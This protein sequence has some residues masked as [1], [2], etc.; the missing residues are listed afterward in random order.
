MD[1]DTAHQLLQDFELILGFAQQG[2]ATIS[3]FTESP[4]FAPE[5]P[6]TL[7]AKDLTNSPPTPLLPPPED[8]GEQFPKDHGE[9]FPDHWTPPSPPDKK[10]A[11]RARDT[12]SSRSMA[13]RPTHRQ[14]APFP[15]DRD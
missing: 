12:N 9:Q 11:R 3:V 2:I 6:S 14:R 10:R 1:L 8:H 15:I 4:N 13:S 7:A 5:A